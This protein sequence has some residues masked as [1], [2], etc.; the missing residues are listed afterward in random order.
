MGRH[1]V[2]GL[3]VCRRNSYAHHVK[4]DAQSDEH[5][6]HDDGHRVARP[7]QRGGGEKTQHGAECHGQQKHPQGPAVLLLFLLFILVRQVI[8]LTL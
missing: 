7:L 4:D 8:D 2:E 6:Q 1:G 5:R 3:R